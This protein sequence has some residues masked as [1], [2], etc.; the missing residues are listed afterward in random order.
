MGA[1]A[2]ASPAR[3]GF[4]C[5]TSRTYGTTAQAPV[6][7][8][9]AR[10]RCGSDPRAGAGSSTSVRVRP[11]TSLRI[12]GPRRAAGRGRTGVR[13]YSGIGSLGGR[14]RDRAGRPG[15]RAVSRCARRSDRALANGDGVSRSCSSTGSTG[16]LRRMGTMFSQSGMAALRNVLPGPGT[17]GG[18]CGRSGAGERINEFF[19]PTATLLE[20]FVVAS[21][22]P[23]GG[24]AVAGR[25]IAFQLFVFLALVLDALAI[26]GQVMV[27]RAL[28]AGRPSEAADAGATDRVVGGCGPA[29]PTCWRCR[30]L[31]QA[32]HLDGRARRGGRSG[33]V[34]AA[35]RPA[36]RCS[37]W[38]DR[39]APAHPP[40]CGRR[41]P[42]RGPSCRSSLA[43]AD[44]GKASASTWIVSD[45]PR[46][47]LRR[48]GTSPDRVVRARRPVT[49]VRWP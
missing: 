22:V 4:R 8:R 23:P 17:R 39:S 6:C 41:G 19:G 18:P 27:G 7:R 2:A 34:P 48:R 37:P 26:A 1:I 38:R 21:A 20:W 31:R 40:R 10:R 5:T 30:P 44:G 12:A 13:R 11:D 35:S 43:G 46:P 47:R 29:S 36:R 28:G 3:G 42:P 25:P 15:L 14:S 24:R 32:V 9:T 49:L 16:L 45:P 33:L